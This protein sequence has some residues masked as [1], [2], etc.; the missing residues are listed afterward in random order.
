M[1]VDQDEGNCKYCIFPE[2]SASVHHNVLSRLDIGLISLDKDDRL[3]HFNEMVRNVTGIEETEVIGKEL[4]DLVATCGHSA[5]SFFRHLLRTRQCST[6]INN[7]P[8]KIVAHDG[9][10]KYL[11]CEYIPCH[12]EGST[13]NGALFLLKD[14]TISTICSNNCIFDDQKTNASHLPFVSFLWKCDDVW[15]VEYVSDNIVQFGYAPEELVSGGLDY[16]DIVHPDHLEALMDMVDGFN[17]NYFSHEYMLLTSE[18]EPRWVLERSYAVRDDV[19]NITHFHG[20]VLDI[21]ERK[22]SEKELA[23]MNL[24]EKALSKLGGHALSCNDIDALMNYAVKLVAETLGMKFGMIMEKISDD[25]FLL[26]YGYGLSEWC[27]GSAIVD[28]NSSSQAGFTAVSGKPVILEDIEKETRFKVPHFLHKHG[29]VSGASVVIGTNNEPFGVLC[30]HTDE[31]VHFSD[32][33]INFLQSVSNILAESIGLRETIGSLELYKKLM[34]QSND[35]IMVLDTITKKFSYVSDRVIQDLGYSE[36][37]LMSQSVF[38]PECFMKTLDMFEIIRKAA[39]EGTFLVGSEF[40]RK[41]GSSFPV[42]ISFSFVENEGKI[43][44]VLIGRDMTEKKKAHQILSES[45]TKLSAIFDNASD[46]ICLS[47]MDG[48]ILQVNRAMAETMGYQSNELIGV[49][50]VDVTSPEFRAD[51][52]KIM[53]EIIEKGPV[54]VEVDLLNNNGDTLPME[55]KAQVIAYNGKQRILSIGRDITERRVLENAIREHADQLE[56][57]NGIKDMFADVTSHDLIGSVSLIEGFV[58]Y[59]SSIEENSEKKHILGNIHDS[60]EKLRR[61]IH[62]ASVFARMNSSREMELQ[63]IDLRFVF[64]SSLDR[65]FDRAVRRN[66]GVVLNSPEPCPAYMNPIIEEVF[67]N[68]MSNAIKY[69]PDGSEVVVDIFPDG[70]RWK[71]SVSDHGPGISDKDRSRI[72]ERFSRADDSG[73]SGKGLG[74]AISR[75]ALKCHGE[76]LHVEDNAGGKGSTFWFNVRVSDEFDNFQ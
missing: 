38:D 12:N 1:A 31:K 52:P 55:I 18:G 23:S 2:T 70:D 67:F 71:V 65:L 22:S 6:Q 56:Y 44:M 28:G 26:R 36:S 73:I 53:A 66:I 13:S 75:M 47:D 29:V 59:L 5:S 68:L 39:D 50:M 43:Y 40:V 21:H 69:S 45:E 48:I 54:T 7:V 11:S 58:D 4:N 60:A 35:Y 46:L 34:N 25:R 57:S 3:I 64:R 33:D 27:V 30:A 61:T 9:S 10:L 17:G 20:A 37:E 15:S 51:V 42:E 72:F 49:A 41:N 8:F 19:G 74:L 63:T 76:E 14:E 32:H 24:Q 62:S 16:A